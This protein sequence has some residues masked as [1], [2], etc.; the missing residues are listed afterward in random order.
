MV[1]LHKIP[2][3]VAGEKVP[4]RWS[5]QRFSAQEFSSL[6]DLDGVVVEQESWRLA[7]IFSAVLLVPSVITILINFTIL[8]ITRNIYLHLRL[9]LKT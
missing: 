7:F 1:V 4:G 6:V 5:W 3:N 2:L 8:L 9:Y